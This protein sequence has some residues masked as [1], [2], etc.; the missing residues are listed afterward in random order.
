MISNHLPEKLVRY[1]LIR[2]S[3]NAT[4]C[5]NTTYGGGDTL[6]AELTECEK[7]DKQNR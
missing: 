4:L 3:K 6:K 1:D 7:A 5:Q 2:A